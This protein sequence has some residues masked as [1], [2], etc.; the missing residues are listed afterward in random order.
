MVS[1]VVLRPFEQSYNNRYKR[2]D[3]TDGTPIAPKGFA[4]EL[5]DTCRHAKISAI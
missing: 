2:I 1:I 5:F 4:E 3:H